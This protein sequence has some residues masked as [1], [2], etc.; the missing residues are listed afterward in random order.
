MRASRFTG[1]FRNSRECSGSYGAER[2]KE[3]KYPTLS[4]ETRLLASRRP[5]YQ[6]LLIDVRIW[7]WLRT[8]ADRAL[9]PLSEKVKRGL[10]SP[11]EVKRSGGLSLG[12]SSYLVDSI[13]A[14]VTPP[15]ELLFLIN[16]PSGFYSLPCR[17][18]HH[19]GAPQIPPKRFAI[20]RRTVG[21]NID[22][23]WIQIGAEAPS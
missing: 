14:D 16:D 19:V 2:L 20:E 9:P 8:G 12:E 6:D 5:D 7:V 17:V 13:L 1:S 10:T 23:T 21:E 15:P 3:K 11:S 22:A 18:D 4:N